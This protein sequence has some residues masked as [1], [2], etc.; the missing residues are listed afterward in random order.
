[1]TSTELSQRDARTQPAAGAELEALYREHVAFVWRTARRMSIAAANADDVVQD[2]FVVVHRRLAEFDG[3]TAIRGWI[4]GIVMHVVADHKRRA[5]RKDGPLT[6]M[7]DDPRGVERFE[8]KN[9]TPADAAETAE[10]WALLHRLL[11]RLPS[12]GR[13]VFVLAK[14]EGMSVPE[15]AEC[16]GAN[17]NTVYSRLRAANQRFDALY[18][19]FLAEEERKLES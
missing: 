5:R 19:E 14:L 15:I 2:T 10:S 18:A 13:E 9:A 6:S 4:Y 7:E 16:V 8:T 12:E 11:A 1:M 3:R 17:V